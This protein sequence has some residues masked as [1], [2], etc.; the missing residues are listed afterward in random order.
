MADAAILSALAHDSSSRMSAVG[1]LGAGACGDD[2]REQG[3][4][5][6][7]G[8]LRRT[9]REISRQ[10]VDP[11]GGVRCR[12]ERP[13]EEAAGTRAHGMYLMS[14]LEKAATP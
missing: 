7:G 11:L 3:P 8:A 13:P 2:L 5:V 10:S 9:T 4:H 1:L 14:L 6:A 12:V